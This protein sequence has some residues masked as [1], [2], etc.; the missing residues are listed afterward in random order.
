MASFWN[1]PEGQ[2]SFNVCFPDVET[3]IQKEATRCPGRL[4]T[5]VSGL[6]PKR[7]S[8]VPASPLCSFSCWPHRH[9]PSPISDTPKH[10]KR[11]VL[12]TYHRGCKFK[13]VQG[14]GMEHNPP[15]LGAGQRLPRP[16]SYGQAALPPPRDATA[17]F[18]RRAGKPHFQKSPNV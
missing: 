15:A 4:R 10:V 9:L 3:E 5:S 18:S 16:P 14:P 8:L 1:V 13:F 2:Y 17:D 6:P 12:N 7:V 11:L